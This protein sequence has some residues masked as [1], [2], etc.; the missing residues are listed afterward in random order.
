MQNW[1]VYIR[2]LLSKIFD[3][4]IDML[5][6]HFHPTVYDSISTIKEELIVYHVSS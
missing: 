4:L 5:F 2:P 3:K 1:V 6:F